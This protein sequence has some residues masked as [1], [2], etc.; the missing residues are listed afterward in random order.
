VRIQPGL[1]SFGHFFGTRQYKLAPGFPRV[2][3]LSGSWLAGDL[4]KRLR[5]CTFTA[6]AGGRVLVGGII[7]ASSYRCNQQSRGRSFPK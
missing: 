5:E 2:F 6:F 1:L 7:I 4:A 3:V